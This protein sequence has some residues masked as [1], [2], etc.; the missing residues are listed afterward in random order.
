[1]KIKK[2]L[3]FSTI[4][5]ALLSASC[6]VRAGD[7]SSISGNVAL[8]SDYV[9]RGYSQTDEGAEISGGFDYENENGFSAG[10]WGSN[11]GFAPDADLE[12]DI[13]ANYGGKTDSD[14]GW[15]VG[16][17]RYMYPDTMDSVSG[18]LDWNEY[19]ASVSYNIFSA[20]LN[21]SN[22][23]YGS[24]ETGIY[25]AF[26]VEYS[27]PEEFTLA[28]GLGFYDYDDSIFGD[29]VED[30]HIGISKQYNEL[31]FDLSYY[32]TNG[33]GSEFYG[34]K[35]AEGRLVFSVSKSL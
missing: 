27:L 13:Y 17:I 35:I 2:I 6:F 23:V 9:W 31:G 1:M 30:Y 19:N 4:L 25:Y 5:S 10:I 3:F 33:A 15:N 12:L 18:D 29:T 24:G 34:D 11:V 26:G 21:Y 20:S 8:S 16:F 28:A 7:D 32:D 22:D 14:I